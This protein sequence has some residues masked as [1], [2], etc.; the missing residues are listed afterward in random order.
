MIIIAIISDINNFALAEIN[1]AHATILFK[2]HGKDKHSDRSYRTMNTL[3]SSSQEQSTTHFTISN[4][5]SSVSIWMTEVP[6]I[7]LFERS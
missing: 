4:Y 3:P 1:T 2:G 5:H 7:A 6:L